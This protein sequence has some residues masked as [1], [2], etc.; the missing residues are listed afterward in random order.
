MQSHTNLSRSITFS[1]LDGNGREQFLIDHPYRFLIPRDPTMTPPALVSQNVTSLNTTPHHLLFHFHSISINQTKNLTNSIHIE[2][3]PFNDR[4]AYFFIARF[5]RLPQMNDNHRWT[6]LCPTL[7]TRDQI[8]RIHFDN[9]QTQDH[10]SLIFGLRELNQTEFD[11]HCSNLSINASQPQFNQPFHFLFNYALRVYSSGCYYL[12][13]N[14]QWQSDG[15]IVG[16]QTN[17]NETECFST[18]V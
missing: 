2:I 3:Q 4:I 1:I 16:S 13:Q 17:I 6:F 5:D 12:D 9:R 11:N 15:L 8:Y 7:L 14:N 18:I 10:H